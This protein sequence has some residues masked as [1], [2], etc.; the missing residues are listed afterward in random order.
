MMPFADPLGSY[1]EKIYKAAIEKA[2]LKPVRADDELFGTGKIIDQIW[3]GIN[4]AKI[5][6]AE[7][8][9]EERRVGKECRSR[10]SPYH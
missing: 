2:G 10:W 4:S 9:S 6:I 3:T 7:L 1:Y 5:L 8:R